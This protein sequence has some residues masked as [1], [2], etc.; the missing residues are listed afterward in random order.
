M[1]T[2]TIHLILTYTII[3]STNRPGSN[4]LKVAKHYQ[5]LMRE[6]GIDAKL[7]SLEVLNG[8]PLIEM[9]MY[10]EQ[11]TLLKSIQDEYLSADKFIV[12]VPEY[13]GS[14]AGITKLFID[15]TDVRGYWNRKKVCLVGVADGRGGNLRGLEHLS[16]IF[17]HMKMNV[18]HL[19][20]PL[21]QIN[22]E[23]DENGR[24][25]KEGTLNVLR[26]QIEGFI[27]F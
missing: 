18:F 21:A 2:F 3:A 12:I 15:A 27:A 7:L 25:Y 5:E 4:T 16:G 14:F 11:P 6:A 19:R 8:E 9:V 23:L 20:Q 13:N 10:D 22:G 17:L 26:G 1:I 24:L